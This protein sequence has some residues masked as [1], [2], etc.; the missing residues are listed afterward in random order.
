MSQTTNGILVNLMKGILGRSPELNYFFLK[1]QGMQNFSGPRR[2][3]DGVRFRR[4]LE[5]VDEYRPLVFV[6]GDSPGGS[7]LQN[8]EL[9]ELLS[10][11]SC[12]LVVRVSREYI[13]A[14]LF[15]PPFEANKLRFS[16]IIPAK[17]HDGGTGRILSDLISRPS[18]YGVVWAGGHNITLHCLNNLAGVSRRNTFIAHDLY[19]LTEDL[20]EINIPSSASPRSSTSTDT[21]ENRRQNQTKG[22]LTQMNSIVFPSYYLQD[23]HSRVTNVLDER[24]SV[25]PFPLIADCESSITSTDSDLTLRIAFFDEK[26][27]NHELIQE[28]KKHPNKRF[29][30]P[31]VFAAN[32]LVPRNRYLRKIKRY[33]PS[34]AVIN[35]RFA[36]SFSRLLSELVEMGVPTIVSGHGALIERVKQYDCGF[37]IDDPVDAELIMEVL[38][39]GLTHDAYVIKKQK[40]LN[41][42]QFLRG[43]KL[44]D[45]WEKIIFS[46]VD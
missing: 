8:N 40:S 22:F 38:Q 36:D 33:Q 15:G 6:E 30:K 16:V 31:R 34:L 9:V 45:T 12:V 4:W 17:K 23:Q 28:F 10:E 25:I 44:R 7:K 32:V 5:E 19:L 1:A 39:K 27:L 24:V 41:Y 35:N 29:V 20:H 26:R 2:L 14:Q 11:K 21:F 13:T 18:N 42:S 3:T 37:V 43:A 46:H